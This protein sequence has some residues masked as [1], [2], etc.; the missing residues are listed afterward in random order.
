MYLQ[1]NTHIN[2]IESHQESFNKSVDCEATD[3]L[4]KDINTDKN[5]Y[6]TTCR[7]SVCIAVLTTFDYLGLS[8]I[9]Q[10]TFILS[11]IVPTRVALR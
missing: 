4:Q 1:S 10:L 3:Q 5:I 9:K 2:V 6:A 8:L 11:R 7:Y